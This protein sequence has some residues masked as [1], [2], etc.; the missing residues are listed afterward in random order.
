MANIILIR[1]INNQFPSWDHEKARASARQGRYG[2]HNV[3]RWVYGQ[4]FIFDQYDIH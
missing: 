2:Q 3:N 4:T 1:M